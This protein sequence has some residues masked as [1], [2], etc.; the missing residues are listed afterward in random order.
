MREFPP[1]VDNWIAYNFRYMTPHMETFEFREANSWL[2]DAEQTLPYLITVLEDGRRYLDGIDDEIVDMSL[3]DIV[4]KSREICAILNPETSLPMRKRAISAM[5]T[6]FRDFLAD[7]CLPGLGH[8]DEKPTAPL[9]SICYMWWD[10]FPTW[11]D[12]KRAGQADTD[13]QLLGVMGGLLDFPHDAIRESALH[14]LGH[15]KINY[16]NVADIIDRWLAR[17]QDLRPELVT[18]ARQAQVGRVP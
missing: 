17:E 13:R 5:G 8:K 3:W 10:M 18:Y 6:F 9:N 11:G 4:G 16:P 1:S 15:W 12:P 14:G 7:R 2:V